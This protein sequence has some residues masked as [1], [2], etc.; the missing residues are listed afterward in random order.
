[1]KSKYLIHILIVWRRM[2]SLLFLFLII[3]IT[4]IPVIKIV[5]HILDERYELCEIYE[6]NDVK[7]KEI[8]VCEV[9]YEEHKYYLI[10]NLPFLIV[11]NLSTDFNPDVPSPPPKTE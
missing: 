8:I 4:S 7:E 10:Q 6:E 9:E 11:N 5:F 3:Y 1:M 2:R